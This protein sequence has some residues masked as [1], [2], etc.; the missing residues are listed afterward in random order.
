MS[1]K[2]NPTKKISEHIKVMGKGVLIL[3][4]EGKL[5]NQHGDVTGLRKATDT[6]SKVRG[7]TLM[8][9]WSQRTRS[10]SPEV[11]QEHRKGV[12]SSPVSLACSCCH[13]IH[14]CSL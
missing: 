11:G 12:V 14:V 5:N 13:V 6:K 9:A 1:L 2:P 4:H 8:R 3:L 10:A 7:E